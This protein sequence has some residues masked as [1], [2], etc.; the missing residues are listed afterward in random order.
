LKTNISQGNGA[1]SF[2]CGGIFNDHFI[3]NLLLNVANEEMLRIGQ[4]LVKIWTK[5]CIGVF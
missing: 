2:R 1:T 3:T 4:Y 5:V